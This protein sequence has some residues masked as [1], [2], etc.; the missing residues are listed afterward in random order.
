M[1]W[2]EWQKFPDPRKGEYLSAP[3]GYGVYQLKNHKT[4][5]FVL[6]GYGKNCAFRMSSL[7]PKP[8]GQGTRKNEVKR[9][10]ILQNIDDILYRTIAFVSESEAKDY[11]RQ[12]KLEQSYIYKT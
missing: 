11:E 5:E 12:V 9:E 4:N 1:S 2:S 6:F 10:Y 8:Y 7:L 3:F